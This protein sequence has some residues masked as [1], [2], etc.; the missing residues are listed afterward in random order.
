MK[1]SQID[2]I[3]ERVSL[4]PY[5]TYGVGGE[6][7]YFYELK[8]L[9]QL[10]PVLKSARQ[11]NVP[12]FVFGGGS[13]V[14]FLDEGFH[15][16]VIRVTANRIS[17]KR[18]NLLAEAG[19]KW[20]ALI[21]AAKKANLNNLEPFNGLPGTIG[22]AVTGNA[23]CLGVEMKD[24]FVSSEIYD[25]TEQKILKVGPDYFAF[26]YRFS[27]IKQTHDIILQVEL[28]PDKCPSSSVTSCPDSLSSR[29]AK[30]P[31]GKSGGSFFKNPSPAQP[32]G[33]L[34]DECGLKGHRIGGAQISEKHANFFMNV[35]N[36]TARDIL[37]LRDLAKN[38]ILK[39]FKIILEE[40]VQIIGS[41]LM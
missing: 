24:I 21:A 37:A 10:E 35:D 22:G 11:D 28:C 40:E 7:R 8:D 30:Q 41:I 1:L 6:A 29:L 3:K 19:A 20:P 39:K 13:N 12:V 27:R 31:P 36:A 15:G 38:E 16:L 18:D 34:I 9:S 2:A 26:N 17:L 33:K 32:A 5:C 14:L 25:V 23:G 4:K